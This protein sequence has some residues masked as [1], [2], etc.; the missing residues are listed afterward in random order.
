MR[1][2]AIQ[3]QHHL[4]TTPWWFSCWVCL[5]LSGTNNG[6]QMECESCDIVCS[7]KFL[8]SLKD[9]NQLYCWLW[10]PHLRPHVPHGLWRTRWA[11]SGT[12]G[13]P[14]DPSRSWSPQV[15][16]TLIFRLVWSRVPANR[17][18]SA[19]SRQGLKYNVQKK[20]LLCDFGLSGSDVIL[21]SSSMRVC[22]CCVTAE[23]RR[24]LA[25][26][27]RVTQVISRQT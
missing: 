17:K 2:F 12:A 21:S 9:Q 26:Q 11:G 14:L 3:Q 4:F 6:G 5:K 1:G 27:Q 7:Q 13:G 20:Y 15:A 23:G 24:R 8:W 22:V 16:K 18:V 19:E 10:C 25:L